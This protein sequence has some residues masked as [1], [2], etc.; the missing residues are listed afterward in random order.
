MN[1]F[2]K[3][4]EFRDELREFM[5]ET[6]TSLTDLKSSMRDLQTNGCAVGQGDRQRIL[7]LES[8]KVDLWKAVNRT[9]RPVRHAVGWSIA[10]GGGLIGLVEVLKQ[11]W[12]AWHGSGGPGTP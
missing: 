4:Q 8:N 2:G 1:E 12:T 9:K 3:T 7:N 6:R 11:V 5:G 10:G